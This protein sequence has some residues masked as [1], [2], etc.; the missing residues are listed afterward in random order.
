M[1]VIGIFTFSNGTKAISGET[2]WEDNVSHRVGQV[3]TCGSKQWK[4]V[5][6]N[7]IYQGCFS[8]PEK[9]YH[10]LKLEPINHT[11]Q[12]NVDDRLV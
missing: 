3:L 6:I 9:R 1:L 4:V 8:K 7:R 12:P 11:D 5:A 10:D 2:I